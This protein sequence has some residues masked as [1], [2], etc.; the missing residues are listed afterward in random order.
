MKTAP[1]GQKNPLLIVTTPLPTHTHMQAHTHASTHTQGKRM[2]S[3]ASPATSH[4]AKGGWG[5]FLYDLIMALTT[6]YF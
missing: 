2:A 3:I 4:Q 1:T 6:S 5:H